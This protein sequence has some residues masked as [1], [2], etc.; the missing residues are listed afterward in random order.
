MLGTEPVDQLPDHRGVE[1]VGV[2]VQRAQVVTRQPVDVGAQFRAHGEGVV[3]PGRV[4]GQVAAAMDDDH[5]QLRV[6]APHPAED[7]PGDRQ[8]RGQRHAQHVDQVVVGHPLPVGEALRMHDRRHAELDGG[9]PDDVVSGVVEVLADHVGADLEAGEAEVPGGLTQHLDGQLGMVQRHVGHRGEPVGVRGD[10]LGEPLVLH[11]RDLA[12]VLGVQPVEVLGRRHGEDLV[13]DALAGHV[14]QPHLGLLEL[15]GLPLAGPVLPV[16]GQ[17]LRRRVQ[18][19]R[20]VLRPVERLGDPRGG[21]HRQ[22]R[23]HVDGAE[24][25][26]RRRGRPDLGREL[27]PPLAL[28]P[29]RF[30]LVHRRSLPARRRRRSTRPAVAS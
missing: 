2:E 16:V 15:P 18:V 19:P 23:V 8:R 29:G 24:L 27:R 28:V 4:E 17:R 12:R 1:D 6:P 20:L 30:P 13:V 26:L 14:G 7:H 9:L 3:G 21:R 22:M 5:R 11:P 10:D 25:R